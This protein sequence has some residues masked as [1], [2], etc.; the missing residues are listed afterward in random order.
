MLVMYEA[1]MV[2]PWLPILIEIITLNCLWKATIYIN[3]IFA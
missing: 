3:P 2:K 1:A